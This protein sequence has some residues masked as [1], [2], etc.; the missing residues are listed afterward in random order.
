MSKSNPKHLKRLKEI[1][2][3]MKTIRRLDSKY[4]KEVRIQTLDTQL[5]MRN[6][7]N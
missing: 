5:L 4:F 6:I 3:V 1:K 7:Y 2:K